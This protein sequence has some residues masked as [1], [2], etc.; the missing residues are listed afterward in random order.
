MTCRCNEIVGF[1][2]ACW[3][4]LR[5]KLDAAQERIRV[6]EKVR[7]D[8]VRFVSGINRDNLNTYQD[9]YRDWLLKSLDACEEKEPTT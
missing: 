1:C 8:A 4:E 2:T 7:E 6:L 3:N 9:D 5:G